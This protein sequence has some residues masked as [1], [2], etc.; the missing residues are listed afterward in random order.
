MSITIDKRVSEILV[1]DGFINYVMNPTSLILKEWDNYFIEN[2]DQI[3]IVNEA[4]Q[5]LLCEHDYHSLP[6]FEIKELE[7]RIFE[8]CGIKTFS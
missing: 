6:P 8:K 4:K 3:P 5:I 1:C 7:M 2:P